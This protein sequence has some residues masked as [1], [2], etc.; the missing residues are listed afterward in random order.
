MESKNDGPLACK[1]GGY[2]NYISARSAEN[3]FAPSLVG[4]AYA[5]GNREAA[6]RGMDPLDVSGS[7]FYRRCPERIAGR[8]G[9]FPPS[10]S[11]RDRAIWIS[12]C[13]RRDCCEAA[14]IEVC[15]RRY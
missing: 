3:S 1:S 8:C 2:A 12:G 9:A 4:E 7:E 11:E 6:L 14:R 13:G 5:A 10:W 15:G